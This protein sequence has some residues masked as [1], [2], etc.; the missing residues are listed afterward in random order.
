MYEFEFK[1]F[2]Y[3]LNLYLLNGV[4]WL[5]IADIIDASLILSG[6]HRLTPKILCLTPSKSF[7]IS[8]VL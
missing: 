4:G 8:V 1:I 6:F 5:K 3:N 2:N 7:S